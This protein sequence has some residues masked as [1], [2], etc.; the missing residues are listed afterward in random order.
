MS[1]PTIDYDKLAA[2]YGGTPAV[3]YDA[4]AAKFGG[5]SQSNE[6]S[7]LTANP[8]HEG[9]YQI[10][11]PKGDTVSVPYSNVPSALDLRG[12]SLTPADEV[13]YKQDAAADPHRATYWNALTNP[14]GSG[15]A[16]GVSGGLE[17]VGGRAIQ[18]IVAPVAHPINTLSGVAQLVSHPIDAAKARV[19]EFKQEWKQNPALAVENAAGDALGTVEG[20]RMGSAALSKAADVSG[21]AAGRAALLGKTPEEAYESALKPSPASFGQDERNAMVK[22]GLDEGIPVTKGGLQ[23]INTLI[24]KLNQGI[25]ETIARDPDRPIA[26]AP[27]VRNLDSVRS[28]FSNQVT[29]QPDLRE[30]DQVQSDFLNNPKLQPSGLGPQPASLPAAQAQAMKS[31]TYTALGDKAYGELKGSNIEAQKALARGLKDEIA[32]QFPEIQGLNAQE[33]KLL[34]LKPVLERAVSRIGNH[35]LIGI[36]TPIAGAAAQ[37]VTGSTT[38]GRVAMVLKGVLD[39]PMVKSRLAIAVSKGG[40]IPYAQAAGR[41]AAYSSALA[42]TAQAQQGGTSGG[43]PSQ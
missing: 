37:A 28:R 12:Y 2:Q 10:K 21:A 39:N 14:V 16:S 9:M 22:T 1:T 11:T 26:T 20:G 25:K 41:V 18:N 7:S 8:H 23:K 19:G 5:V 43:I 34:D 6:L 24:D 29:P 36:G 38:V 3:D 42:A 13:R 30:I 35:Q 40:K 32:A 31:G 15:A 33:S 27:A 4:L 17:Q